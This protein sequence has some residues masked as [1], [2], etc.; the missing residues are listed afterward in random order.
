MSGLL[1]D[2]S[3]VVTGAASGNRLGDHTPAA[4]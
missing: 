4:R 1:H 3:V 2:R